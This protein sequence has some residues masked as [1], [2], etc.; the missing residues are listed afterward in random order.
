MSSLEAL[1]HV[2]TLTAADN[3][4]SVQT[5]RTIVEL[6]SSGARKLS[7]DEINTALAPL[8]REGHV[9]R[10]FGDGGSNPSP[11]VIVTPCDTGNG[12]FPLTSSKTRI[13][14][15]LGAYGDMDIERDIMSATGVADE[16]IGLCV[17]L[18]GLEAILGLTSFGPY[19]FSATPLP[20][21]DPGLPP[22]L[23]DQHR[24]Q[25]VALQLTGHLPCGDTPPT[26]VGVEP[27]LRG[28]VT[29]AAQKAK[30]SGISLED[31]QSQVCTIYPF[32]PSQQM[33]GALPYV[34]DPRGKTDEHGKPLRPAFITK[35]NERG[36]IEVAVKRVQ[37]GY[38]LLYSYGVPEE[39]WSTAWPGK[40]VD[41]LAVHDLVLALD[42]YID[43]VKHGAFP[44]MADTMFDRVISRVEN[45][46]RSRHT[47]RELRVLCCDLLTKLGRDMDSSLGTYLPDVH[48]YVVYAFPA[49]GNTHV[50]TWVGCVL[51]KCPRSIVHIQWLAS[52]RLDASDPL[53]VETHVDEICAEDVRLTSEKQVPTPQ[54]AGEWNYFEQLC[55]NETLLDFSKDGQQL[56]D[57][58]LSLLSKDADTVISRDLIVPSEEEDE[59][60][61]E[62]DNEDEEDDEDEEDEED[63]EDD[64]EDEEDEEDE[65]SSID[66]RCMLRDIIALTGSCIAAG[67]EIGASDTSVGNW[68]RGRQKPSPTSQDRILRAHTRL[69]GSKHNWALRV[70]EVVAAVGS[71]VGAAREIGAD[72]SSIQNWYHGVTPSSAMQSAILRV[73]LRHVVFRKRSGPSYSCFGR[74]WRHNEDFLGVP[75]ARLCWGR[76]TAGL[77]S[78]RRVVVREANGTQ[79]DL[80]EFIWYEKTRHSSAG[81]GLVAQWKRAVDAHGLLDIARWCNISVKTAW[82]YIKGKRRPHA[83]ATRLLPSCEKSRQKKRKRHTVS[84]QRQKKKS[85]KK[86]KKKRISYK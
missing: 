52:I 35:W 74:V 59:E 45:A 79:K 81:A 71:R 25:R 48:D 38:E 34:N 50:V 49:E 84:Q 47:S 20:R 66:Y 39:Y 18:R 72:V 17:F 51:R 7:C 16:P 26:S 54:R 55:P 41:E 9:F 23:E 44:R 40:V 28:M 86:H 31:S 53:D 15:A 58:R 78:K 24:A 10:V 2:V 42:I 73:Y 85:N 68:V 8:N 63:E 22:S 70:R 32:S 62:D 46:V 76:K 6:F 12:C 65:E 29:L 75:G 13:K 37:T 61:E 43:G 5:L 3:S 1:R 57:A 77:E 56:F 14:Y 67:V 60:D 11:A 4:Q 64:D 33:V 69:S 21:H 80:S 19:A 82:M 30:N 83:V 36:K 27:V